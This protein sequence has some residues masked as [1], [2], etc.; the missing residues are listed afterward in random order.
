[1]ARTDPGDLGNSQRMKH[2]ITLKS[3][4]FFRAFD[5]LPSEVRLF[6]DE[7]P[8]PTNPIEVLKLIRCGMKPAKIIDM[9]K[10]AFAKAI[11][12]ESARAHGPQ[13]PQAR[14]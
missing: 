7:A 11:V 12:I 6:L 4:D 2:N 1:M 9:L 8:Y 13:H 5:A 14:Q 10:G 3:D